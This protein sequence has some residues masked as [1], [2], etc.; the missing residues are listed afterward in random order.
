MLKRTINHVELNQLK[1]SEYVIRVLDWKKVE[2]AKNLS[3]IVSYGVV[4]ESLSLEKT[5]NEHCSVKVLDNDKAKF[6]TVNVVSSSVDESVSRGGDATTNMSIL[7]DIW[8]ICQKPSDETK[9]NIGFINKHFQGILRIEP[10][11]KTTPRINQ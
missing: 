10:R 8:I 11:S 7:A 9:A 3:S 4:T 5:P 2:N 1:S 6:D